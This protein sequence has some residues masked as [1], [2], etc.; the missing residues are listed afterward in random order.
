MPDITVNA[1]DGG[2]FSAYLARPPSG[3][4]P[5]LVVIQEIL[6]VN[7]NI[8]SICDHYAGLGYIALAPDLFWRQEK[9]V[10]LD[11]TSKAD[12]DKAFALMKGFD[13]QKGVADIQASLTHVRKLDGCTGKA[14]VLGF[15]LGGSLA[16]ATAC[17]T[18]ADC[19]VGYYPVQI[20][21]SLNNAGKV[22]KPVLLH[23]AEKDQFCPPEA[24]KKI[25]ASLIGIILFSIYP[26]PGVG[27]AFAREGGD[28][29][30]KAAA[31]LANGRT[32]KFLKENLQ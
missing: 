13:F 2:S 6:G 5:G 18:D 16:Y 17:F 24:Q 27:H 22:T 1:A 31:E 10:Q 15:C 14:G 9:G 25:Y 32:E 23:M 11:G 20:E 29:Y 21:N 4:G 30:D 7:R 19:A 8:R 3:K 12:W 28:T 26:Y